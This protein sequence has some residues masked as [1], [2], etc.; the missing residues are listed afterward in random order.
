MTLLDR[1]LAPTTNA[2]GFWECPAERVRDEFVAW[3][4]WL[5][6][7]VTV[8][9]V[10]GSLDDAVAALRPLGACPYRQLVFQTSS[11]W[12]AYLDSGLRGTDTASPIGHLCRVIPCRGLIAR[13]V[14]HTRRKT[15]TGW[16]GEYGIV[17]FDLLADHPAARLNTERAILMM[18]DGGPWKFHTVG[19]PLPFEQTER[20]E[21][22]K[23]RDRFTVD[24]LE[25]YCRAI[26]VEVFD[27]EF[28]GPRGYVIE[29]RFREPNGPAQRR[30]L[31]E[32]LRLLRIPP[33]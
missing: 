5:N 26:G 9:E 20:Y 11:Q 8:F 13:W 18:N 6:R 17:D 29:Q 7:D 10:N 1:H 2:I 3:L 22:K 21:A 33:R 28:Y 30:P 15:E 31:D 24:M 14:P 4:R 16:T 27:E 25:E 32:L 12:T 19:D 23:I